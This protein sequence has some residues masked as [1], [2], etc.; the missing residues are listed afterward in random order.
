MKLPLV[1]FFLFILGTVSSTAQD[2]K[3]FMEV[4]KRVYN[5]MEEEDYQRAAQYYDTLFERYSHYIY[6]EEYTVAAGTNV[7]AGNFERAYELLETVV[8]KE[9]GAYTDYNSLASNFHLLPLQEEERWK[10]LMEQVAENYRVSTVN[11]DQKLIAELEVM[12]GRFLEDR[13]YIHAYTDAYGEDS[14]EVRMLL[15]SMDYRDSINQVELTSFIELHGI[16]GEQKIGVNGVQIVFSILNVCDTNCRMTFM[17]VVEKAFSEGKLRSMIYA[18]FIDL[19]RVDRGL[20]QLYG[21][22]VKYDEVSEE[23]HLSP[24]HDPVNINARRKEV[25]LINMEEYARQ[26]GL[27]WPIES[28]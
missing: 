3:G 2:F 20:G 5:Y 22:S 19:L 12:Y 7:M 18:H 1:V 16:L 24:I 9:F 6:D 17:P 14:K 10:E 13:S 11:L 23:Y 15:D 8:Y 21:T 4:E 25:G 26:R 27:P 28:E